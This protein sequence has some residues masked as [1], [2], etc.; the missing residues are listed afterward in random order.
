MAYLSPFMY[1]SEDSDKAV[2][3]G[4]LFWTTQGYLFLFLLLFIRF[5][6][7][8]FILRFFHP[9]NLLF[10]HVSPLCYSTPYLTP[11]LSSLCCFSFSVT[12][13]F[14]FHSLIVFLFFLN[15]ITCTTACSLH[16]YFFNFPLYL[17]SVP[18]H[19][20]NVVKSCTKACRRVIQGVSLTN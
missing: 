20:A 10:R 18:I 17:Q 1:I 19:S 14:S 7:S 2:P 6:S 16:I 5:S 15:V 13:C 9:L 11:S 4:E 12:S 3:H 8:V